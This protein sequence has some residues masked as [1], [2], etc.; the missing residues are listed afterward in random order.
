MTRRQLRITRGASAS[1]VATLI[2]ALSHTIGGGELPHPLLI[3]ASSVFLT[4]LAAMLVGRRSRFA[5]IAAAVAVIQWVFHTVFETTGSTAS[6]GAGLAPHVHS[7]GALTP[8]THM[9]HADAPMVAAHVIAAVVTTLLL[10]RGESMIHVIAQWVRVQLR[11]PQLLV[12]LQA[13][14]P[15]AVTHELHLPL[16][17]LPLGDVCRRG[18]PALSWR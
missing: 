8:M 9:S 17:R 13:P 5:S 12:V 11:A 2:A 3:V 4:P 1:A 14:R 6:S 16:K 15:S 7:V 10:W 18:P